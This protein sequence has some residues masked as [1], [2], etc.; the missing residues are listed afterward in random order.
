MQ[1]AMCMP[2]SNIADIVDENDTRIWRII[3]RHI[4]LAHIVEDY[5]EMKKV[6]INETSSKRGHNYVTLFVDMDNSKVVYVT[7]GKDT[8]TI[9]EFKEVLPEYN[10]KPQNIDTISADMSSAFKKGV[11]DNLHMKHAACIDDAL[12]LAK[13]KTGGNPGITVILDGVSV[14]VEE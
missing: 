11:E 2:V 8:Q 5:S 6:G 1:L 12:E 14:V 9:N 4:N 13:R 7:E 10:C 3:H